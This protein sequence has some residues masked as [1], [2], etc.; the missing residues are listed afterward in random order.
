MVL[1]FIFPIMLLEENP[2]FK[3]GLYNPCFFSVCVC[4]CIISQT[5]TLFITDYFMGHAFTVT[6]EQLVIVLV[7]FLPIL[8]NTPIPP[9]CVLFLY[10]HH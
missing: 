3:T 7:Y 2:V 5:V 1:N 6:K 8:L 9:L 10:T 4:L